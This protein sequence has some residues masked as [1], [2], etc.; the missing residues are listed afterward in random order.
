VNGL[1]LQ[2]YPLKPMRLWAHVQSHTT[3]WY[4]PATPGWYVA[5][6]ADEPPADSSNANVRKSS[7]DTFR[8]SVPGKPPEFQDVR[9]GAPIAD[10]IPVRLPLYRDSLGI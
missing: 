7:S 9:H 1:F 10:I 6:D 5:F 8:C 2:R 4:T 3:G